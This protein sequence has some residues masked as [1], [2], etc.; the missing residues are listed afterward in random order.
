M[1]LRGL[2]RPRHRRLCRRKANLPIR[3]N[4][5]SQRWAT[6][7]VAG[8]TSLASEMSFSYLAWGGCPN[9]PPLV[10]ALMSL[11]WSMLISPLMLVLLRTSFP[12]TLS[13]EAAS[14]F[15]ETE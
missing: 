5:S 1:R 4:I 13:P 15:A 14:G 11:S 9:W 12:Q 7:V 2:I 10:M 8:G 6:T 3:L